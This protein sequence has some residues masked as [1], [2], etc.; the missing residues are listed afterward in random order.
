MPARVGVGS[1]AELRHVARLLRQAAARD[2]TR[3][4]RQGQRKAFRPLQAEIK[5]EAAATLP[6][7]GGYAALMAKAVRVTV[8]VLP[9]GKAVITAR[10]FA[11]GKVEHRDVRAVNRGVLRHPVFGNRTNWTVT[12]VRPGFVDRPADRVADRV[13]DESAEAL[14]RVLQRIARG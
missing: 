2:I 3:E 7:R 12:N 10:V 13:L 8:S 9:R 14:G 1:S 11:R 4:F 6:T 5:A